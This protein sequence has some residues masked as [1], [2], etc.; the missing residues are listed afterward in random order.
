[1]NSMEQ[2]APAALAERLAD[3]SRPAPALLDVREPW[4]I[5]TVSLPNITA[6][7]MNQ[8]PA[9]IDE[10]DPEAEIVCVCHHGGRSA[11]VAMFLGSRGFNRLYNL[12]GGMDAYARIVDPSLPTY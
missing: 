5:Q 11:Q 9:R 10:L 6:I 2:L 7:P 1:M 12:Q 3:H 4:E 8:I